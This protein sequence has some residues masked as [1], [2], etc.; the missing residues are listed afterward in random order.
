MTTAVLAHVEAHVF[1]TPIKD[2][3]RTSFGTMTERAAVFV[4]IEDAE[5][6]ARTMAVQDPFFNRLTFAER[7]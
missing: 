5:W 1:R 2:P 6:G 3:V 7:K 4:R